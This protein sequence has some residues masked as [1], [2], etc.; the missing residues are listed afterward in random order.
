MKTEVR[1]Q[2]LLEA[3]ARNVLIHLRR[4]AQLTQRM[5]GLLEAVAR[6]VEAGFAD[7]E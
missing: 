7:H 2:G 4:C 6:N 1:M 3:V 5:Q